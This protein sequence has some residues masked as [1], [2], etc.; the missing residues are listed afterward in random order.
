[1]RELD[2]RIGSL[3]IKLSGGSGGC[4]AVLNFTGDLLRSSPLQRDNHIKAREVC[5]IK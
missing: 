3:E 2:V 1:M 4:R 5:R